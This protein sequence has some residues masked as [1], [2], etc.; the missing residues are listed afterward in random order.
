MIELAFLIILVLL[1]I[2]PAVLYQ[3]LS[4]QPEQP[5]L[6]LR[7]IEITGGPYRGQFT[8]VP[9][10]FELPTRTQGAVALSFLFA[11]FGLL[12]VMPI[13]LG[14]LSQW[15]GTWVVGLP[16]LALALAATV[17]GIKVLRHGPQAAGLAGVVGLGQL[18]FGGWLLAIVVTVTDA[19]YGPPSG[20]IE[21]NIAQALYLVGGQLRSHTWALPFSVEG[22]FG[23][24]PVL[25]G[26]ASLLHGILLLSS[27]RL[28][29]QVRLAT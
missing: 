17:T 11:V 25:Y 29:S 1:L 27:A 4:E 8:L 23:L 19:Q 22:G 6:V 2:A 7:Q 12:L 21:E 13:L 24:L 16:G 10:P 15:A 18:L 5:L 26:T 3:A 9:E 20:L 28:L 14:I